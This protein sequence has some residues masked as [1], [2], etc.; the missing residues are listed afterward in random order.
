MGGPRGGGGGA[1]F[2][3][4]SSSQS[5]YTPNYTSQNWEKACLCH[6]SSVIAE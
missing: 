5:S 1:R 6:V 4:G 2:A 3:G